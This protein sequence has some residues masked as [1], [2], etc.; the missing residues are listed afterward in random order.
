NSVLLPG[1]LFLI[2]LH[3]PQDALQ[4][5]YKAA[6]SHRREGKVAAAEIEYRAVLGEAYHRIGKIHLRLKDYAEAV[7]ALEPASAYQTDSEQTLIDLAIAYFD[8]GLPEKAFKPLR[9]ALALNQKSPTVHQM[10]GKN[11]F[12]IGEFEKSA[13]ELETARKL[14]PDDYDVAYTLGLAYLKLGQLAPAK[15]IYDRMLTQLGDRPQLHIVFGRAYRETEFL[16]EAIEEF[17]KAVALDPKFPRAHYYLG[18]TY[19]LKDG[20][21]RLGDAAEE[22][23]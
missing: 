1:L 10:L 21:S 9:E 20:G 12:M 18:L 19:L 17:K 4:Q 23:K 7:A 2:G 3:S 13:G 22:F 5:H 6:E 15:L 14:A 8:A 16:A 11:Y